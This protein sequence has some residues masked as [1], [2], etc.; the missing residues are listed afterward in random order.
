[1]SIPTHSLYSLGLN[2]SPNVFFRSSNH[3]WNE[4]LKHNTN[5]AVE[6]S[7]PWPRDNLR[8]LYYFLW[9]SIV[10]M[11]FII[12]RNCR[13]LSVGINDRR[14][15]AFKWWG[16][17]GSDSCMTGCCLQ[18]NILGIS[19]HQGVD[20]AVSSQLNANL[21]F[22]IVGGVSEASEEEHQILDNDNTAQ[23][24]HWICSVETP[25][26]GWLVLDC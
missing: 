1:M 5:T 21:I 9:C 4:T 24:W 11:L 15:D 26:H 8:L 22:I 16:M 20:A 17:K 3:L 25:W 7:T 13:L 19:H 6:S 18:N 23:S 12:S 2:R 10:R 14:R